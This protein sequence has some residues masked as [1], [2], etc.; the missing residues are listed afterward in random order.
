MIDPGHAWS[1]PDRYAPADH[2]FSCN[3]S[4]ECTLQSHLP[5]DWN[6]VQGKYGFGVGLGSGSSSGGC[7]DHGLVP[8]YFA[9]RITKLQT[10]RLCLTVGVRFASPPV[11]GDEYYCAADPHVFGVTCEDTNDDTGPIDKTS[12]GTAIVGPRSLSRDAMGCVISAVHSNN[13]VS[14][15]LSTLSD[16]DRAQRVIERFK[17]WSTPPVT[18]GRLSKPEHFHLEVP[19]SDT[20]AYS[21][22]VIG[23]V[24]DC[25]GPTPQLRFYLNDKLLRVTS[26][27]EYGSKLSALPK[28][29]LDLTVGDVYSMPITIPASIITNA[30]ATGTG[31][32]RGDGGAYM[33]VPYFAAYACGVSAQFDNSWRPPPLQSQPDVALCST[34]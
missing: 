23:V 33:L 18:R 14:P 30:S 34:K 22:A 16:E 9:L 25:D 20:F 31:P 27:S 12:T 3:D 13:V 4:V 26:R 28:Q 29:S 7:S 17:A 15:I 19:E 24:C 11:S 5:T 6:S 10:G 21:G 32:G 8:P 2:V 1:L